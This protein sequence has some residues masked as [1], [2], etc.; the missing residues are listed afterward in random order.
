MRRST[1]KSLLKAV[2]D[3]EKTA[4]FTVYSHSS[5]CIRDG[6]EVTIVLTPA[7][8]AQTAHVSWSPPADFLNPVHHGAPVF[9]GDAT[10]ANFVRACNYELEN[11]GVVVDEFV[12]AAI[13]PSGFVTAT[14]TKSVAKDLSDSNTLLSWPLGYER[15]FSKLAPAIAF[16]AERA[17]RHKSNIDNVSAAVCLHRYHKEEDW[18][19]EVAKTAGHQS[20]MGA[21]SKPRPYE[22]RLQ[23]LLYQEGPNLGWATARHEQVYEAAPGGASEQHTT[24]RRRKACVYAT[25]KSASIREVLGLARHCPRS[26]S[27]HRTGPCDG[28]RP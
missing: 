20:A 1:H 7:D 19:L 15:E 16:L 13:P 26:R 8:S 22:T 21:L 24:S 17:S 6:G 3:I 10:V 18:R 28:P 2:A 14:P 23:L 11:S 4:R 27:P 5:K 12:R 9:L 25:S